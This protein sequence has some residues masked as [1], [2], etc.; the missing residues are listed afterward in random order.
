MLENIDSGKK[1]KSDHSLN[2]QEKTEFD[3]LFNLN[4]GPFY[5][6]TSCHRD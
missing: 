6:I 5:L 2:N 4:I 1:I 3:Y